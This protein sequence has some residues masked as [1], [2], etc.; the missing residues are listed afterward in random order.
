MRL[1]LNEGLYV[2]LYCGHESGLKKFHREGLVYHIAFKDQQLINETK[3]NVAHMLGPAREKVFIHYLKRSYAQK[4]SGEK[5]QPGL[6]G[7]VAS[8]GPYHYYRNIFSLLRKNLGN[9]LSLI[10]KPLTSFQRILPIADPSY[11]WSPNWFHS[12]S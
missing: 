12:V 9:L 10:R 3:F 4:L 1:V 6:L 8:K 2:Q 7:L 5:V 11:T